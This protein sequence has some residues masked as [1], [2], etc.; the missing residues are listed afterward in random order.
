MAHAFVHML[1]FFKV[2]VDIRM[3]TPLNVNAKGNAALVG[4]VSIGFYSL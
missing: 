1:I 2:D 4:F 3:E